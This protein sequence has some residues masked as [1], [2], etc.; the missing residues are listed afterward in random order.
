[1]KVEV[2][3]KGWVY[4]KSILWKSRYSTIVDL[5]GSY[6]M[7]LFPDRMDGNPSVIIPLN[8]NIEIEILSPTN[9]LL[10]R[11][12]P[13]KLKAQS[14]THLIATKSLQER[15]EF[16]AAI[17]N[18]SNK[19]EKNAASVL[20]NRDSAAR[21]SDVKLPE[22]AENTDNMDFY[23]NQ[24]LKDSQINLKI[25]WDGKYQELRTRFLNELSCESLTDLHQ[26]KFKFRLAL[27]HFG[28]LL[29]DR[30]FNSPIP[31]NAQN[32]WLVGQLF[33]YLACEYLKQPDE[34][35]SKAH[36]RINSELSSTGLF[37]STNTS[38]CSA[39][40][41]SVEYKGFKI[42]GYATLPFKE[43]KAIHNKTHSDNEFTNLFNLA[44]AELHLKPLDSSGNSDYLDLEGFT[45]KSEF[46]VVNLNSI[47]PSMVYKNAVHVARPEFVLKQRDLSNK[48][49]S[50]ISRQLLDTIIP[51]FVSLLDTLVIKPL[52]GEHMGDLMHEHGINICF[53]GQIAK[54]SRIP[55]IR[56]LCCIEMISRAFKVILNDEV[57]KKII[58]FY[59]MGASSIDLEI[60]K[61]VVGLFNKLAIHSKESLKFW[62][63]VLNP[64][65]SFKYDYDITEND[66]T[67]I[68]RCSLFFSAQVKTGATFKGHSFM[69]VLENQL[70]TSHDF[71]S[72]YPMSQ[73]SRE[74][75]QHYEHFDGEHVPHHSTIKF[76]KKSNRLA[77]D[78]IVKAE[79]ELRLERPSKALK[80]TNLSISLAQETSSTWAIAKALHELVELLCGEGG[81]NV[82]SL[83]ES[84]LQIIEYHV[85]YASPA[86]IKILDILSE[87]VVVENSDFV[88]VESLQTQKLDLIKKFIG[89]SILTSE[90]YTHVT[91]FLI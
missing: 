17:R 66:A 12:Y 26:L 67:S 11:I 4:K 52:D 2:I 90:Q 46:Y 80:L 19:K 42:V 89:P 44:M 54:K 58:T 76:L 69:S 5:E 34:L 33:F 22:P 21:L 10:E 23:V 79:N 75:F 18:I 82:A 30:M 3:K 36:Q 40:M 49:E 83:I 7:N 77:R 47:L 62:K 32:G 43:A 81:G 70:L 78:F 24:F 73:L 9:N 91:S 8:E 39:L 16:V 55:F 28:K 53:L 72:F 13:F 56:D 20:A 85:G 27:E 6:F 87:C 15:E 61:I 57:R 71:D 88:L 65:V 35:I 31:K 29:I 25:D 48:S 41:G 45:S 63:D 60:N 64:L 59:N 86:T 68:P 37:S 14:H 1:M 50:F 74:Y 51:E 84:C 38:I